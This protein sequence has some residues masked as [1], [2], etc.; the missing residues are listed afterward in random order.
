MKYPPDSCANMWLVYILLNLTLSGVHGSRR[1]VPGW[2]DSRNEPD[3]G[4]EA[5]AH[6]A[7]TWVETWLHHS[8]TPPPQQQHQDPLE[9]AESQSILF[10]CIDVVNDYTYKYNPTFQRLKAVL[11]KILRAWVYKSFIMLRKMTECC[12]KMKS[13]I[14]KLAP[15]FFNCLFRRPGV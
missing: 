9:P 15:D 7:V 3:E 6:A 2:R 10:L 11:C 4:P 5:A 8:H 13:S 12:W 1:D 14:W